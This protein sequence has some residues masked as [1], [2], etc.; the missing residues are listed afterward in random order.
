MGLPRSA[1]IVRLYPPITK[2][3][4]AAR[5][6][7]NVFPPSVLISSTPPSKPRLG[8]KSEAS[9]LK[10]CRNVNSTQHA[11]KKFKDHPSSRLS[12]TTAGSSIKSALGGVSAGGIGSP[13]LDVIQSGGGP[14]EFVASQP[15]GNA[16][17]VTPSKFSLIAI[18][19]Q[20]NGH[21]V[22]PANERISIRHA[23]S[24]RGA[25]PA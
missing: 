12:L 6:S 18:G 14:C 15:G 8:S 5:M 11:S 3:P 16:G 23:L 4:P 19:C 10:L 2:L 1:T 7:W 25:D 17:G 22:G 21:D 9:R 24:S 20:Q 13:E